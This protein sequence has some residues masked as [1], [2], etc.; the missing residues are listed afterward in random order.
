MI[1]TSCLPIRHPLRLALALLATACL[2]CST[3]RA[4]EP[5]PGITEPLLDVTVSSTIAGTLSKI[6]VKEGEF[7]KESQVVLELDKQQ[8]ELE[9]KRRKLVWESK[10]E[11]SAAA[12]QMEML[13]IDY[14]GT[15]RL[16]ETTKS[17]S[18]EQLLKK[19]QEYRQAVAE[20]DK[21]AMSETREE[22]EYQ[23]A[24]E[25]LRKRELTAPIGGM[26]TEIFREVG[27]DCKPQEPL[28]RIVDVRQCYFIAN[29]DAKVSTNLKTGQT[30][31][32]E[33]DVGHDKAPV[34]GRISFVSPVVDPASGL[35]KI[36][37]IFENPEGRVKAGVAGIMHFPKSQP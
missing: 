18:K 28:Y 1:K 10:A 9:V 17:V 3:T 20:H 34:D 27:E 19:E 7:A 31:K 15:K 25:A 33:I 8:E 21:L 37:V 23:M 14:D 12:A 4:Q 11:L 32:L 5:V 26:I 22:L 29:V 6:L 35:L 24:R 30:V 2:A 16:F 13:K 36:K